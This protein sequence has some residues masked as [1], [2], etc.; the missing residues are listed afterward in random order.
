MSRVVQNI[1]VSDLL[2]TKTKG[3]SQVQ[4]VAGLKKVGSPTLPP[5]IQV[6]FQHS[7]IS[8]HE[9]C[10]DNEKKGAFASILIDLSRLLHADHADQ[11]MTIQL[12]PLD[13][14]Y[15]GQ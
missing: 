6:L 12:T 11:L 1:A 7:A 3:G 9:F 15:L 4:T 14:W 2:S 10:L 8:L 13:A 5:I